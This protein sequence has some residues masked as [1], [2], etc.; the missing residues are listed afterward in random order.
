MVPTVNCLV[1]LSEQ[2][3]FVITLA[4]VEIAYFERVQVCLISSSKIL[5]FSFHSET[6]IW[7][8]YL[9]TIVVQLCM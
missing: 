6:L 7:S 3:F 9:K 8:L 4:E 5:I 2:P 1:H